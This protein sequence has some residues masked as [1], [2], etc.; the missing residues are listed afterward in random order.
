MNTIILYEKMCHDFQTKL[1][2]ELTD[3]EH[4]FLKWIVN[5][6]FENEDSQRNESLPSQQNTQSDNF[7]NYTMDV[8][9]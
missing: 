1:D 6:K 7:I 2:R 9:Y 4:D 8:P 3:K 5:Q